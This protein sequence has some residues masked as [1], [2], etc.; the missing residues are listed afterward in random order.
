MIAAMNSS[1]KFCLK[2]DDF[3]NNTSVTFRDLWL[4]TDLSDVTLVGEGNTQVSTHKI[5]LAASSP[6]FS[7][8]LKQN[9]HPHPL[10]YM[11]GIKAEYLVSI[12]DF[13]YHGE[14][15]M[16]QNDLDAFL[17]ITEELQLKGLRGGANVGNKHE[18]IESVC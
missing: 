8:M 5:I 9:K 2:W 4:D 3:G 7:E 13:I 1:R 17:N 12:V 6:V 10:I 14:T 16:F 18:Y 11:R 15:Q